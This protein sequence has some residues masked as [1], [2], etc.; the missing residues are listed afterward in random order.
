MSITI[1]IILD[2]VVIWITLK[3]PIAFNKCYIFKKKLILSYNW[4]ID[5]GLLK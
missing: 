4:G 1:S 2:R 5:I 3:K